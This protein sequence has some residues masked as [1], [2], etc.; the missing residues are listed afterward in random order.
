MPRTMEPM[1][2]DTLR[3]APRNAKDHDQDA[4]AAS[5]GRFGFIEPI[6]IDERTGF[7]L[8]GHGRHAHLLQLQATGA[9]PPDGIETDK[10]GRWLVPV[11]R[12]VSS[13]NDTEA[14]AMA[15]ALNRVG[16]RGGWKADTLAE[17]LQELADQGELFG[18]GFD[19]DEL[20]DIMAQLQA[21]AMPIAE[22]DADFA[23]RP[24]RSTPDA[25]R[26]VQGLHEVGVMFNQA[27][28][29]EYLELLHRL[30]NKWGIDAQP[31]VILRAMREAAGG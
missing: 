2:L 23:N 10:A 1:R 3:P 6:V 21:G 18:T 7:I 26:A 20:D 28:H 8:S 16:E 15:V 24:E 5:V 29:R 27:D 17:V 4:H 30:K 19:A 12:G 13:K 14:D 11:V 9:E 25:P 22:T 31:V